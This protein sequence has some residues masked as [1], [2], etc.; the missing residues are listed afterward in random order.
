MTKLLNEGKHSYMNLLKFAGLFLT[1]L[2]TG[3]TG[4]NSVIDL[5]RFPSTK[6]VQVQV[7]IVFKLDDSTGP[8]IDL[9]GKTFVLNAFALDANDQQ[10]QLAPSGSEPAYD[11]DISLPGSQYSFNSTM[12]IP[13]EVQPRENGGYALRFELREKGLP[14]VLANADESTLS[15]LRGDV[16][17]GVDA[18][19][20]KVDLSLATTLAARLI[21][22]TLL[23][24]GTASALTAYSDLVALLKPRLQAIEADADGTKTQSISVFAAALAAGLKYQIMTDK[25]L[26]SQLTDK[27]TLANQGI[28]AEDKKAKAAETLAAGFTDT[29]IAYATDVKTLLGDSSTKEFGVFTAGQIDPAS[30]PEA[31]EYVSAVFAPVSISFTDTDS[32]ATIG[33]SLSITPPI[34]AT[35]IASYNIYFGGSS[36]TESKGATLGNI[37]AST[38]PL[39]LSVPAGTTVPTNMTKFWIYPVTTD[40]KELALPAWIYIVNVGGSNPAFPSAPTGLAAATASSKNTV[41]WS[42]VSGVTS[43]NLYWSTTSPVS[44][45]SNKITG[46]VSPHSH[47]GLSVGTTY[48]Y[49]V[50]SVKNGI[51]SVLSSEV[52]GTAMASS[53]AYL[54]NLTVSSSSLS[55]TFTS[56]TASYTVSV[57]NGTA[58]ITFTPTVNKSGA[59]VKINNVTVVS[60]TASSAISLSLGANVVTIVV[61]APDGTTQKTYTVTVTRAGLSFT[62]GQAAIAI[63]GQPDFT[64]NG[65]GGTAN[66]LNYPFDVTIGEN[67]V[68]YVADY[69]NNRVLGFNAIPTALP[70]PNADFVVG[71]TSLT[72][73]SSGI[74]ASRLDGPQK[75][76]Q[77]DDKFYVLDDGNSRALIFDAIPVASNSPPTAG[78]SVAANVAVGQ[79]DL[80]TKTRACSS[81][82]FRYSVGMWVVNG[83]M[84]VADTSNHRVLI[85]N[86]MP[87]SSGAAADIVIGQPDMTTCTSGA[88][89]GVMNNPNYVWSDGTRVVVTDSS[90]NRVLIWNEFP[91][92]NGETADLVLGQPDF[93]TATSNTGGLSAHSLSS[94]AGVYSNGTQLYIADYTNHR[95]LIWNSFPTANNVDASVVI[96]Q[97]NFTTAVSSASASTM[98][99]PWAFAVTDTKLLIMDQDASRILIYTSN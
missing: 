94:P 10:V 71:Q 56:S 50:T 12:R 23:D 43:Y 29:L 67:G 41:T 95:A 25:A 92:A 69:G 8:S 48:Y 55:S 26:Q 62:N 54:A 83:K 7:N 3:C 99:G 82:K 11:L 90:N 89:A 5:Y 75:V 35:G 38:A 96:G 88:T 72:G 45:S 24:S 65:Q 34:V 22:T 58:S 78:T 17:A 68:I 51:E 76:Q 40:G 33:G 16:Q 64:S 57:T 81:T 80:T 19:T 15:A 60:G 73:V 4:K 91:T 63:I 32:T 42:A 44:T 66:T 1:I 2:V 46:A 77:I 30:I 93:T 28:A 87:T 61:T 21:R 27:I 6:D 70:G 86:T 52:Q 79:P 20:N 31:A 59:T 98:E 85:Y 84:L 36:R 74:T 49:A 97:P 53:D 39:A 9:A 14:L 18:A 13:V 47:K 37:L